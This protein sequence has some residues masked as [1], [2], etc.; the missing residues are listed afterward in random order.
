MSSDKPH[1]V[2]HEDHDDLQTVTNIK[3][4]NDYRDHSPS[5]GD[6]VHCDVDTS[7]QLTK[8]TFQPDFPFEVEAHHSCNKFMQNL[9]LVALSDLKQCLGT[10]RQRPL[11]SMSLW[12]DGVRAYSRLPEATLNFIARSPNLRIRTRKSQVQ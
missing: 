7:T 11:D 9:T 8:C 10:K 6:C 1:Y 12:M 3:R 2:L 4:R 5:C